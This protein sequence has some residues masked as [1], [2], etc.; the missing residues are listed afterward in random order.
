MP[1]ILRRVSCLTTVVSLIFVLSEVRKSQPFLQ[2]RQTDLKSVLQHIQKDLR[3]IQNIQ[4][5]R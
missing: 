1:G 2:L 5:A 4:T 3:A